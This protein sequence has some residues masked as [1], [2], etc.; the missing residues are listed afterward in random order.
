MDE[1]KKK[2]VCQLYEKGIPVRKIATILGQEGTTKEIRLLRDIV[3]N[4]YKIGRIFNLAKKKRK[5]QIQKE[6]KIHVDFKNTKTFVFIFL[7]F[8]I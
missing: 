3:R 2:Q 4:K 8:L 6:L 1:I 7:F 5:R